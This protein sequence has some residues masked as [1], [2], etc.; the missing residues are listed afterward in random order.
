MNTITEPK[1][2]GQKLR[3]LTT[4]RWQSINGYIKSGL[5]TVP[6]VG[7]TVI[8]T[9]AALSLSEDEPSLHADYKLLRDEVI[10]IGLDLTEDEATE[11]SKYVN[12][13]V[14][15]KSNSEVEVDTA[16]KN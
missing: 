12:D 10:R 14:S 2:R 4:F 9:Y 3:P 16:G 6:D 11:I 15:A 13:V 8:Y 5:S 7:A 1:I